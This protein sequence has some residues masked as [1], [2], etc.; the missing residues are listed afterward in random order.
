MSVYNSLRSSLRLSSDDTTTLF[1]QI[2]DVRNRIMGTGRRLR[3]ETFLLLHDIFQHIKMEKP[4]ADV[5]DRHNE[6]DFHHDQ[7]EDVG[8]GYEDQ[9]RSLETFVRSQMLPQRF[10][11]HTSM[12]QNDGSTKE[13][14]RCLNDD[15]NHRDMERFYQF[16]A[17]MPPNISVHMST[18]VNESGQVKVMGYLILEDNDADMNA[19]HSLYFDCKENLFSDFT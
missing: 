18:Y 1:P 12:T 4:N 7:L 17:P 16:D 2:N 15:E 3:N 6:I 8:D 9:L 5:Q 11:L 14:V 10:L 13:E 19:L